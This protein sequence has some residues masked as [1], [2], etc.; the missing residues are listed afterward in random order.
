MAQDND[1]PS[2]A[3][4]VLPAITGVCAQTSG[5]ENINFCHQ[6]MDYFTITDFHY[7]DNFKRYAELYRLAI[8]CEVVG[9]E[10]CGP[11]EDV[12]PLACPGYHKCINEFPP[13]S[14][15]RASCIPFAQECI[16]TSQP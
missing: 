7:K 15:E 3:F 12:L 13:K 4:Q 11:P 16:G 1:L 2:V 6:L 14:P 10:E 8:P 5:E 9:V